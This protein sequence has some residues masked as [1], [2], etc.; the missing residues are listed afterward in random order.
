MNSLIPKLLPVLALIMILSQI[1]AIPVTLSRSQTGQWQLLLDGLPFY[2]MGAGGDGPKPLLAACGANTIRSW[3][4]DTD[5][6]RQLDEAQALGL[7]VI[8]GHWLGHERH[9]FSYADSLM[10]K[11]QK[12]RVK[13]DVLAFKDHPALLIWA[14]GNEMEGI[15]EADNPALWN[16]I[17]DLAAMVKELDPHHPTMTVTADIGGQR[18]PLIH[19]LCP[20]IDIV[21][22]NTY[23][24]LPSIPRRYREAGGSKPYLIT[25]FGPPGTWETGINGFGVPP[26]LSST[27]KAPFYRASFQSGCLD[28]PELCLGGLAFFW[29]AKP[30]ATATWFGMLTPQGEKLGAVDTMAMIWSGKAPADLCPEIISFT[31]DG[32]GICN[33]GDQVNVRLQAKDP[34]G[35][36]LSVEWKVYPEAPNYL[37]FGETWWQPLELGHIILKSS[38]TQATLRMPGGGYYRLYV[39]VRDGKGGAATANHPFHVK[40]EASLPRPQLP[41]AVYQDGA[42]SPWAPSGWMGATD[43]LS[44]ELASTEQPHQGKTCIMNR[45]AASS[46][47]AGVVWQDPPNDWGALPGGYDLRGAKRLSFWARGRFG[48]EKLTFGVGLLAGD[49]LYP[50]SDT[51]SLEGVT[52]T[53]EWKRYQIKL[54]GKD[55]SRIKTPFWWTMQGDDSTS[56][57]YLDDVVF[58]R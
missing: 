10:L 5:T 54:K 22:I 12:E 17:Q 58:E 49:V 31:M 42:P 4:I 20:D 43:A 45:L 3:G 48:G 27:Q 2:V 34:E 9:G 44:V 16:H 40:G 11:E 23:G 55:L 37:T 6:K 33:P 13:K 32:P 30:E 14:L 57:F 28:E 8:L 29:G 50:D 1:N 51:A 56:V 24:G 19:Q 25:E 36:R 35:A 21:G 53:Y 46:S 52:L 15:G 7:K 47:W 39:T 26:E 38:P 18:V 41:L